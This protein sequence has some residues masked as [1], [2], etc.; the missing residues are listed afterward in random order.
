MILFELGWEVILGETAVWSMS[1]DI[2]YPLSV[3]VCYYRSRIMLTQIRD[4]YTVI[5]GTG[6]RLNQNNSLHIVA[7]G[8]YGCL[9]SEMFCT[10]T[11]KSMKHLSQ[12]TCLHGLLWTRLGSNIRR[13]SC[14]IN[15]RRCDVSQFFTLYFCRSRIMLTQLRDIYTVMGGT[16][17]R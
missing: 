14:M 3:T 13:N 1:E 8:G 10:I 2:T 5:G 7:E 17:S 9:N 11:G 12:N 16:G 4:I 15:V 6:K